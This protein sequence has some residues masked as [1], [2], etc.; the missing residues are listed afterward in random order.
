M[1]PS[2][3][4]TGK[5][6]WEWRRMAKQS[7]IAHQ[8]DPYEVDWLLQS[9]AN[10]DRLTLYLESIPD[11]REIPLKVSPDRLSELWRDRV[12]LRTP[13][14]YLVGITPWRDF[15]LVVSPAVLIPRPETE[16]IVDMVLAVSDEEQQQGEWVDLG[17]G[18]G[19]IAI[20]LA[21][22]LP[23]AQIHAVDLSQSALDIARHNANRLGVLDR[24]DFYQGKWWEPIAHLR[25]R[26]SGMVSNPP[27]IPSETVLGLQAEVVRHEPH[28]ALDGGV[29]GL[30]AIR[31][32]V[33]TAPEYLQPG[34]IWLIEMMANQ[35]EQVRALLMQRGC[36]TDIQIIQDLAGLDRFAIARSHPNSPKGGEKQ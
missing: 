10:L 34:G 16:A 20:G 5:L 29:D 3:L 9:L 19:A 7:A 18:S 15:E 4:I 22:K 2:Y 14:Q 36:Y 12:E 13:V 32:L 35:G 33:N 25:G 28:L 23:Q 6:L 17:T 8:I 30:E 27:Y 21:R 24:V 11:D 1:T 26:L 31:I